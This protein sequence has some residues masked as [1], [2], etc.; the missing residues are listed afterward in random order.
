MTRR[1]AALLA[2]VVAVLL[3][4]AYLLPRRSQ[5]LPEVA[6]ATPTQ[7]DLSAE[8]DLAI[9]Q[10]VEATPVGADVVD[11][12]GPVASP[13][14]E[15]PAPRSWGT[16]RA[17][18]PRTPPTAAVGSAIRTD[19]TEEPLPTWVRVAIVAAALAAFFAVSLIATKQV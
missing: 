10:V 6:P 11:D 3:A 5:Q 15:K 13:V 1:R 18:S 16:S 19:G 4:S 12:P 14:R 7:P 8:P 9:T 17:P 2:A